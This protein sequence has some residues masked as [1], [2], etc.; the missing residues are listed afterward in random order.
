[1]SFI[2]LYIAFITLHVA[3]I[4]LVLI[5]FTSYVTIE[6]NVIYTGYNENI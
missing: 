6:Y 5:Y 3:F 2:T 1:M 4:T